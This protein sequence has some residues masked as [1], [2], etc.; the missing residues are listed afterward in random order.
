MNWVYLSPHLDDAALSCGGLVWEQSRAGEGVCIWTICTGD[1]PKGPLSLF[2][3]ELHARWNTGR[4]AG[5]L[6]RQEDLA[7]CAVLG[8]AARHFPI[9]DCIYRG[10]GINAWGKAGQSAT[11]RQFYYASRE[12]IFGEVHPQE[13]EL[14]SALGEKLAEAFS[15]HSQVVCPLAL[16]RHVD[17]Q[18]TRNAAEVAA[19]LACAG[20]RLWYYADYPYVLEQVQALQE[21][22]L[23]GW[24]GRL[25]PVSSEGMEAW[26]GGVAAHSSQISTFWPDLAEMEKALRAY[27]LGQGGVILWQKQ[28]Q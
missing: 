23:Q 22:E 11:E 14:M 9:P 6:R 25:F 17:H 2:A 7:S 28:G 19:G 4:E 16:G 13:A 21:L 1:A 5:T 27:C 18:L 8:A 12:A 15:G 24:Q 3:E 10:V 26:V 20:S